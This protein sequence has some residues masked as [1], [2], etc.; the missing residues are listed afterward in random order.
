MSIRA[1]YKNDRGQTY[2]APVE[3]QSDETWRMLTSDGPVPINYHFQDDVGG[4]L[5]FVEYRKETESPDLRLHIDSRLP[6]ESSFRQLQRLNAERIVEQ[7]QQRSQAR[8]QA[9]NVAAQHD[10]A[11][12]AAAQELNAQ[13][14]RERRPRGRG[15]GLIIGKTG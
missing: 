8:T 10:P 11:K 4:L 5:T 6:G 13:I 9:Q 3:K 14:L 7:R 12:V 1:V 15:V 2:S